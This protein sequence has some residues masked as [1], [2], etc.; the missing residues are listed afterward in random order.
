[1]QFSKKANGIL[2]GLLLVAAAVSPAAAGQQTTGRVRGRVIDASGKGGVAD[3]RVELL[4]QDG[5]TAV[6][7]FTDSAG[8]FLLGNIE[9][10]IY[11]IRVQHDGYETYDR[12]IEMPKSYVLVTVK[13]K[14]DKA[15]QAG[16]VPPGVSV[17]QL[18]VPR[19]ARKEFEKGL[20]ELQKKNRPENSLKHFQK[21]VELYP[22]YDE[23]YFQWGMA[24]LAM[25][26]PAEARELAEQAVTIN[27]E[28]APA[29]MLLGMAHR[30]QGNTELCL[31]S[32][33]RAAELAPGLWLAQVELAEVLLATGAT[34]EANGHAERAHELNPKSA[35]SHIVWYEVLQRAKRHDEALAEIEKLIRLFPGDSITP[36]AR[37][38]R[39]RL[40]EFLKK[41]NP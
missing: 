31:E 30:M 16:S 41:D 28:N 21:A 12:F 3:A 37:A 19:Q 2:A 23:A 34:A 26:Q 35:R 40:R 8:N 17:K 25:N 33:R 29:H 24:K 4:M 9:R 7:T 22:D 14:S 11:R 18:Q 13:P 32:Y 20:R 39:D 6:D 27:E 15:S 38:Q 1:M 36:Q 10:G 5:Q